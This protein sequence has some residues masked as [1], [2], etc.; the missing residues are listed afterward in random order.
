MKYPFSKILDTSSVVYDPNS[1]LSS[2]MCLQLLHFSSK[3]FVHDV[4]IEL[5]YLLGSIG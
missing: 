2:S 4:N 5:S 3:H 1:A